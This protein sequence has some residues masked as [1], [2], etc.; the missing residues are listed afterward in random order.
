MKVIGSIFLL[1]AF[2]FLSCGRGE[3]KRIESFERID[4]LCDSDPHLAMSML[5]S[6]NY[7]SLYPRDRH[8][9]DLHSKKNKNKA[10]MIH[11]SDSLIL[12][13]I[14]YYSHHQHDA[15]Y[16]EALYYG[17]RVYS[18]MGDLPTA[19]KY[20]QDAIE[21]TSDEEKNLRFKSNVLSQTGRLLE[22]LR[23]YRQAI[24]YIEKSINI[25]KQLNDSADVFYDYM[26]LITLLINSN[27]LRDARKYISD[28]NRYADKMT[29]EDKVWLKVQSALTLLNE[30]KYDS[31]L[32]AIRPLTHLTDSLCKNYTIG[33]AAEIYKNAGILDTAYMYSKE[34]ALDS[35][36]NNRISGFRLLFSSDIQP[37]IPKDSILYLGEAFGKFMDSYLNKYDSQET[38][39]QNSKYNYI[40]KDQQRKNA[41]REKE[42]VQQ[43]KNAIIIAGIISILIFVIIIG[44]LK[45]RNLKYE[46]RLRMAI[47]LVKQ[48]EYS[49]KAE[50][51]Q[52]VIPQTPSTTVNEIK[53][54]YFIESH[55]SI[56]KDK[57]IESLQHVCKDQIKKRCFD[58]N[59]LKSPIVTLLNKMISE[60]KGISNNNREIWAE[61]EKAV[62]CSSPEFKSKL[63]ILTID[64]LSEKEYQ[65]ALL[66]RCGITPRDISILLNRAKSTITDRRTTLA[67]KIFGVKADNVS[68]DN[69]ILGL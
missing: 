12:D 1:L 47:Q 31:A 30:E 69:I 21:N 23:L 40:K 17:G 2:V 25:S 6:I 60:N 59:L 35:S 27:S 29:Y 62:N 50:I 64:K 51:F 52:S 65:V 43:E 24:P 13:V 58:S 54:T 41:E 18:D 32:I 56:L 68:L 15:F 11:T 63:R 28:A 46:L 42:R 48:L 36:F 44:L 19:L 33:I 7:A 3:E 4:A 37:L 26:Q 66:I 14:D 38:L 34:L 9:Y 22:D 39:I 49:S 16:P 61:I 8:R 67:K 55:R 53:D 57:L 20:F 5:D 10:Y 45:Y